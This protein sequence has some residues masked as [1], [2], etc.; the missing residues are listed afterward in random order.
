M[1]QQRRESQPQNSELESG[2]VRFVD[3]FSDDAPS[4]SLRMEVDHDDLLIEDENDLPNSANSR[5]SNESANFTSYDDYDEFSEESEPFSDE[6][7]GQVEDDD[8]D[9]DEEELENHGIEALFGGGRT[10]PALQAL[11]RLRRLVPQR[12]DGGDNDEGLD[13]SG[14]LD[15]T[16]SQASRPARGRGLHIPLLEALRGNFMDPRTE[17]ILRALRSRV[18]SEVLQGLTE[19]SNLLL[20]PQGALGF[21]LLP[22]ESLATALVDILRN[23]EI[24]EVQV[25]TA[26]AMSQ[27]IDSGFAVGSVKALIDSGIIP[28]M[29]RMFENVFYIDLIEQL[30]HVVKPV[31][32]AEPSLVLKSGCLKPCVGT[33]DFFNEYIQREIMTAIDACCKDINAENVSD[34][35]ELLLIFP[36]SPNDTVIGTYSALIIGIAKA[37]EGNLGDVVSLTVWNNLVRYLQPGTPHIARVLRAVAHT[38]AKCPQ[39]AQS[40]EL[41]ADLVH[42]VLVQDSE[43][44]SK[45][46]YAKLITVPKETLFGGLKLLQ[47][48]LPLPNTNGPFSG[49]YRKESGSNNLNAGDYIRFA[50]V[51]IPLATASYLAST[52]IPVRQLSILIVLQVTALLKHHEKFSCLMKDH[53]LIQFTGQVISEGSENLAFAVGGLDIAWELAQ[54]AHSLQQLSESGVT[55]DLEQYIKSENVEPTGHFSPS[56]DLTSVAS[57]MSKILYRKVKDAQTSSSEDISKLIQSVRCNNFEVDALKKAPLPDL[58]R[59]GLLEALDN[60]LITSHLSEPMVTL[61]QAAVTRLEK[62]ELQLTGSRAKSIEEVLSRLVFIRLAEQGST[63]LERSWT[64]SVS[65]F[66][67]VKSLEDF[68]RSRSQS[69]DPFSNEASQATN[70]QSQEQYRFWVGKSK[71]PSDVSILKAIQ[72]QHGVPVLKYTKIDDSQEESSDESEE[73]KAKSSKNCIYGHLLIALKLLR[74]LAVENER[75]GE[76]VNW[77]V[78]RSTKITAKLNRQL[79]DVMSIAA[80]MLP[81]WTFDTVRE[82]PFLYPLSVRLHFVQLTSFGMGRNLR[83]LRRMQQETEDNN[84]DI[85]P[86]DDEANQIL[87]RHKHQKFRLSRDNILEGAIRLLELSCKN[88]AVVEV[89]FYAEEG[90]GKGPTQE[91]FALVCKA[92]SSPSLKMW[93]FTQSGL[94]PDSNLN[95]DPAT[96]R[97]F[98]A[99]GMLVARALL[100]KRILDFHLNPAFFEAVLSET[101]PSVDKLRRVDPGLASSMDRLLDAPPHDLVSI[102]LDFTLPGTDIELLPSGTDIEVTAENVGD[103]VHLICDYT[104]GSGIQG[105]IDAFRSGFSDMIPISALKSFM[106]DELTTLCGADSPE[107]WSISTLRDSF[108]ADHGYHISSEPVC[109]FLNIL[110]SFDST[111]RRRFLIFATG[112]PH[113]PVGGFKALNPPFT[114]VVKHPDNEELDADQYLPSVMTCA[115]Y[116]KLPAYSSEKI[117]RRQLTKA[118]LEGS[119]AFLLS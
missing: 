38:A 82:F 5:I 26:R 23:S 101:G 117:M 89:M 2:D 22:T 102:G 34:A 11:S 15:D 106:L 115:N 108:T 84:D 44:S 54:N 61:L 68:V 79:S 50:E 37:S 105:A 63:G 94:F 113:L 76:F 95:P 73:F 97:N 55:G 21:T 20:I 116:F 72:G 103:Y 53:D 52:N 75:R 60:G 12:N 19:L 30:V 78:F 27:M 10:H 4:D 25:M 67:T 39:Y 16:S 65:A 87:G 114:V 42:L 85:M 69:Q 56:D 58:I 8:D 90:T 74:A 3:D 80:S 107:D 45:D 6:E 32:T 51:A 28:V 43:H 64:V 71:I 29:R 109:R 86:D 31:A 104:V 14:E 62:F 100:D 1:P 92:L 24:I 98:K 17:S 77:E 48:L 49:P 33:L 9:N 47:V 13:E 88:P 18:D 66:A 96:L 83:L 40:Y 110:S 59:D 46:L 91:F 118:I 81:Q 7:L 112:S 41:L 35:N 70:N 57:Y 93:K 99:M 119:G 111:E 36:E